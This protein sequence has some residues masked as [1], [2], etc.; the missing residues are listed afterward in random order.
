MYMH[1]DSY[2]ATVST[3]EV[4]VNE[5]EQILLRA[6][7][8]VDANYDF[9]EMDV[10]EMAY[11]ILERVCSEIHGF[12]VCSPDRIRDRLWRKI[13][14]QVRLLK[15]LGMSVFAGEEDGVAYVRIVS[16]EVDYAYCDKLIEV[17]V[18][19]DGERRMRGIDAWLDAVSGL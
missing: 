18:P 17:E 12:A 8:Y 11:N 15:T 5:L 2:I 3:E 4:N 14:E 16:S 1:Y 7:K 13:R 19:R 10:P 9:G 6:T